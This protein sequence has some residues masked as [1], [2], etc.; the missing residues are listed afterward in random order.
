M[1]FIDPRDYMDDGYYDD[2]PDPPMTADDWAEQDAE[3]EQERREF[4]EHGPF[5][6]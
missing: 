5:E 6:F 2:Q 3:D 1:A 4:A